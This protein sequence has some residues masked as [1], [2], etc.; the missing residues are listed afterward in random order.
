MCWI[1]KDPNESCDR[2]LMYLW[3]LWR[4][5]VFCIFSNICYSISNFL[6]EMDISNGVDISATRIR[7]YEKE[8]KSRVNTRFSIQDNAYLWIPGNDK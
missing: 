3:Q 7:R 2:V 5:L 6:I 1:R 8:L 4:S